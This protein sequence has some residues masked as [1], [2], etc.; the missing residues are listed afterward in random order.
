VRSQGVTAGDS[1]FVGFA[2][3]YINGNLA[4]LR[5][6][7]LEP[8]AQRC[9]VSDNGQTIIAQT[10]YFLK[11]EPGIYEWRRR[12][13]DVLID[14]SKAVLLGGSSGVGKVY[15]YMTGRWHIDQVFMSTQSMPY[16][17]DGVQNNVTSFDILFNLWK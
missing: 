15:G 7:K 6:A 8:N 10:C 14:V 1:L 11:N 17:L 16:P 13:S 5:I 4:Y 2:Y 12:N 9:S 3:I